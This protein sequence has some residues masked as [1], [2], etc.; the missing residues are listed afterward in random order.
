MGTRV[1]EWNGYPLFDEDGQY[2][3]IQITGRDITERKQMEEALRESEG[4]YRLLAENTSDL[5]WTM[6][7][8]LRYTYMSPAITR[9]RGYT[10]EEIVGALGEQTP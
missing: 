3:G 6:D 9:M 8:S 1:V 4:R 7:L 2:A 5:I 10:V